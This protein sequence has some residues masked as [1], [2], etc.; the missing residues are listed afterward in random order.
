[1]CTVHLCKHAVWV[2]CA[3]SYCFQIQFQRSCMCLLLLNERSEGKESTSHQTYIRSSHSSYSDDG[4]GKQVHRH[5]R[6]FYERKHAVTFRGW[7][8]CVVMYK[9]LDFVKVIKNPARLRHRTPHGPGLAAGW[10]TRLVCGVQSADCHPN[11]RS[12]CPRMWDVTLFMR[13]G[14]NMT[15]AA[16]HA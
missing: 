7:Q 3:P 10:S 2:V 6:G 4:T 1:M 15:W 11:V 16:A 14:A 13:A 9:D 5:A 8:W 12:P